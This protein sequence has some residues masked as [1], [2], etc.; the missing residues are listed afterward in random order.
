MGDQGGAFAIAFPPGYRRG[1]P[2]YLLYTGRDGRSE[3]ASVPFLVSFGRDGG[4]RLYAVS[5]HGRV[6]RL[7]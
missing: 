1:G 2:V 4:G 6:Y 3:H 5:V 7:G